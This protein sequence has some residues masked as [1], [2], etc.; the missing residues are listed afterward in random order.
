M[1][2]KKQ[3]EKQVIKEEPAEVNPMEQLAKESEAALPPAP[4]PPVQEQSSTSIREAT[5]HHPEVPV[6]NEG[7]RW[8]VGEVATST[9]KV[10]HD[11]ETQMNYDIYSVQAV[12]LNKLDSILEIAKE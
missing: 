6:E 5:V 3:K 1:F 10:I 7:K 12:I 4:V 11:K 2:R 9:E 8:V